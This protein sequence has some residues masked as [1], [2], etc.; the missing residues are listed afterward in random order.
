[1]VICPSISCCAPRV[2]AKVMVVQCGQVKV[3]F[4]SFGV[5]ISLGGDCF[6][7]QFPIPL[8]STYNKPVAADP[9]GFLLAQ[10]NTKG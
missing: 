2:K 6:R 9:S 3:I 8:Q 4:C 5:T 7:I 10:P 1:M